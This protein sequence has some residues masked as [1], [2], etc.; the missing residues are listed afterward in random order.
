[1]IQVDECIITVIT[2]A[3]T[4]IDAR[5][6]FLLFICFHPLAAIQSTQ[7]HHS[8][9]SAPGTSRCGCTGRFQCHASVLS[10]GRQQQSRQQR[11][12]ACSRGR[13]GATR[14]SDNSSGGF[15]CFSGGEGAGILGT[16]HTKQPGDFGWLQTTP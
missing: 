1:M 6:G 9:A 15:E 14:S 7:P 10:L 16:F 2:S 13:R 11:S 3:T 8:I 4:L 5:R 12:L